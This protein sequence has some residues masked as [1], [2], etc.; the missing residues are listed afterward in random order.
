M[1]NIILLMCL[2]F[3]AHTGMAAPIHF[4]VSP[5]GND[6][7]SGRSVEPVAE[8]EGPFATLKRAQHAIRQLKQQGELPEPVFVYFAEGV[9]SLEEPIRFRPEDSGFEGAPISYLAQPGAR[10][11]FSA[12]KAIR[13]WQH[14]RDNRWACDLSDIATKGWSFQQLFVNG[15]RRF[16]ARTPN[17]GYYRVKD[18][19]ENLDWP[20]HRYRYQFGIYPGDLISNWRNIQDIDIVLL[21]FWSD[22]HCDVASIDPQTLTVTL[23]T[24]AWRRFTDDHTNQGARYYVENVY[25]AMDQPGEWYYDRHEQRLY[26]LAHPDEDMSTANVVAGDLDQILMFE[27]E[28]FQQNYVEHI[29]LHGLTFAHNDW[30]LPPGDPGDH[31]GAGMV[32]GAV[33]LNGARHI[34]IQ[35]CT[36]EHGATYGIDV[37]DGCRNISLT[38]NTIHDMGAGGI[39]VSGSRAGRDPILHTSHITITDNTLTELGRLYN[40]AVGI[41]LMHAS[42]SRIAHNFIYDL[43]YTGIS[44]GLEWGYKPSASY[45]NVVDFNH[46]EKAG[47]GLLSDMGGIY[48]LGLSPGTVIRNNLVHNIYTHGYGGW[49]IYT[50]EGSSGILIEDN[51]VYDTKS[52]G[53]HQHYGKDNI[54]RNNIFAFG[55]TAQIMRSRDE[56]HLSFKFERNIIYWRNSQLMD[57]NWQGDTT[58]FF[59]EKN[60]YYRADAEP[61][62]FSR[63]NIQK[64]QRKGL[65]QESRFE[66]PLFVDPENGDFNLQENS[67]AFDIGFQPIDMTAIGPRTW[68]EAVQEISYWSQADSTQQ[69]ALFY[70]SGSEHAKPLLVGLHTWSGDYRQTS[71]VP[72]ANWC[73]Q[74]DWVLVHPN[75]RGP[76]NRPEATGSELV[77]GDIL[78]AVDYA[79]ENANVD[80]NRIYLIG[81]SGGGYTS[82]LMAGKTPQV[83]AGISAWVPIV[84]LKAW[85]YESLERQNKYAQDIVQSCGGPPGASDSVDAEYYKRSPI[86]VLSAAAMPLDINAGIYDGHIGSVPISH[87]LR[88]FNAVAAPA[89]TL[90][91]QTMIFFEQQAHVPKHLQWQSTDPFYGEKPVLFRRMSRNAR[92]SLFE[93]G[94][95]MIPNAALHWLSQQSK[96]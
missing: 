82:L 29:R 26:Y 48:T 86:H 34:Q 83:W 80:T 65:D 89:D 19:M 10:V 69:P 43:F 63:F 71:S 17:E 91:R 1:Q 72:Y 23:A 77:V 54:V 13:D 24:P 62:K 51:I 56:E 46:I 15:E 20:F 49:G 92:I 79:L 85:Y 25:E 53:F 84:D 38:R 61:V 36:V 57:K 44:V 37:G 22:A 30:Q 12:G 9:Y 70:D 35:D 5:D 78:S 18:P 94:H 88:A 55:R 47:Q 4:Y 32:P 8:Q 33:I 95:D 73:L 41:F 81:S 28:P 87:S 31:Q 50:D 6:L 68:P 76:N 96:K 93:G 27:G 2:I 39:L 66:D 7:W 16:R 75:F 64:W 58:N 14:I 11:L 40:S 21:H 3:L 42:D 45:N 74:K 67:P 90:D 59:F 52:A 60:L